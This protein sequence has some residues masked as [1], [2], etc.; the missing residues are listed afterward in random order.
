[1]GAFWVGG[2]LAEGSIMGRCDF[3]YVLLSRNHWEELKYIF[4]KQD[5]HKRSRG[6]GQKWPVAHNNLKS[7]QNLKL[8][9][10][11]GRALFPSTARVV[12][13][14]HPLRKNP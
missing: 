7:E 8:I 4:E 10:P 12:Y 6:E 2:F 5:A 3:L 13:R 9:W 14:R 1:M 11:L